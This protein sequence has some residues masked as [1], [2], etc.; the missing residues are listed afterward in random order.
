MLE[1]D[2]KGV[3]GQEYVLLFEALLSASKSPPIEPFRLPFFFYDGKDNNILL[4]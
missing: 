2:T 1:A 3:D 4:S